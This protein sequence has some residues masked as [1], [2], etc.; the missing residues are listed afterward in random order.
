MSHSKDKQLKVHGILLKQTMWHD[1]D[2]NLHSADQKHWSFKNTQ[3]LESAG[4]D[5][6][7]HKER[8]QALKTANTY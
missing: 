5:T 4:V 1:H 6:T 2:S 7:Q 8:T 3:E